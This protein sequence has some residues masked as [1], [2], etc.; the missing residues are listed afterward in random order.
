M[1][2]PK[3]FEDGPKLTTAIGACVSLS[4][5]VSHIPL[6]L[7]LSLSVYSWLS[8]FDLLLSV[9]IAIPVTIINGWHGEYSSSTIPHAH[10]LILSHYGY[11]V[12]AC[13]SMLAPSSLLLSASLC[14]FWAC[15][16]PP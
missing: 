1:A 12:G 15:A 13:L 10:S 3:G 16:Q 2:P 5:S 4:L 7:S 9:L 11:A 8:V 14:Y 6:S